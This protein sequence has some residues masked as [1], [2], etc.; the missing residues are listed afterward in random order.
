MLFFS[1]YGNL[2]APLIHY[3]NDYQKKQILKIREIIFSVRQYIT[4]I[5]LLICIIFFKK[6]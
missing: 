5:T 2:N 1:L 6:F 4:I 3:L